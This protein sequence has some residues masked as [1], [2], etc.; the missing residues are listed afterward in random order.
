MSQGANVSLSEETTAGNYF[1]SNYPPYSFWN[2]EQVSQAHEALDRAPRPGAPLGIYVHIP[3]CRK[4][5]HFCYFKVYT[6]KDS[7]EIDHYLDAKS[8]RELTHYS[9]K[10][11]CSAISGWNSIWRSAN[12]M[13]PT[14]SPEN[15]RTGPGIARRM[16]WCS[17]ATHSP[18]STPSSVREYFSRCAAA[19]APADVVDQALTGR[20]LIPLSRFATSGAEMCRGIESMRRLVYTF[21]DQA[22]QLPPLLINKHPDIG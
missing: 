12:N 9:T 21:Y 1:V 4:R 2:K 7:G 18:S 11:F 22:S 17:S 5:C 15:T 6:G 10:A 13:V 14:A 16:A 20:R 3:F 19:S 8:I